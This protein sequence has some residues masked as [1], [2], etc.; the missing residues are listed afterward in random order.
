MDFYAELKTIADDMLKSFGTPCV[1]LT[2][3]KSEYDPETGG[4]DSSVNSPIRK[5]YV[6]QK[7]IST[8]YSDGSVAR[9]EMGDK[10]FE[11]TA[12]TIVKVGDTIQIPKNKQEWDVL[13]VFETAPDGYVVKYNAH[14]RRTK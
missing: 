2:S 12:S 6:V 8:K 5:G 10:I 13:D 9:V 7:D 3:K 4:F 1:V 11:L 14:V